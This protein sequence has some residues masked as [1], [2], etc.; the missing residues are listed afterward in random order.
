MSWLERRALED[1]RG[2]VRRYGVELGA[3]P[4]R[5]RIGN[6][7]TIW[8]SCSTRG[9]V[10]LNWRL[11]ATPRQVFEYVVVHELCHLIERNH[12]PRF[13]RLVQSLMPDYHERRAWLKQHGIALG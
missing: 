2:W 7:K 8:G 13:W 12:G 11:I 10:S 5:I 3:Y 6:Q 1:A 9:V 4:T